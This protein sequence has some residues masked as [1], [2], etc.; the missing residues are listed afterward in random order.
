M[1]KQV[2]FLKAGDVLSSGVVVIKNPVAGL[3]TPAGKMEIEVQYPGKNKSKVQ[4]WGKYTVVSVR[5]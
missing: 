4:T 2:Q 5:G 3:K 1:T